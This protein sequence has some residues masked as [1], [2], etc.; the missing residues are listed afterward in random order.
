MK[1]F[2]FILKVFLSIYTFVYAQTATDYEKCNQYFF[3]GLNRYITGN[4]QEA[5]EAF[6]NCLKIND[7]SAVIYFYLAKSYL[8]AHQNDKAEYYLNIALKLN[9]DNSHFRKLKND[10]KQST[11]V[12][13]EVKT[14]TKTKISSEKNALK[15]LEQEN[16]LEKIKSLALKYPFYPTLQFKA[17]QK[18][19]RKGHYKDAE[20]FLLNGMDFAMTKK[21]LLKKYYRLLLEI[22]EKTGDKEKADKY[23]RLINP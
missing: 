12:K 20:T 11:E 22:Y 7:S 5:V 9:P 16:E 8:K 14:E 18:A 23:R 1:K 17:A 15:I 10:L 3:S 6:K 19:F 4:A 2:L 21:E 13:Y